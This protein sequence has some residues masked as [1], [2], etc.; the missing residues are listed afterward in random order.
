VKENTLNT[1]ILTGAFCCIFC[2]PGAESLL[3]GGKDNGP[4]QYIGSRNHGTPD[5]GQQVV[6]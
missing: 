4:S 2:Y 3:N 6:F 5:F 1:H